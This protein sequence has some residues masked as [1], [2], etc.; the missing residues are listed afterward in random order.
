MQHTHVTAKARPDGKIA[1]EHPHRF[2]QVW[3][4][5]PTSAQRQVAKHSAS[6]K[7]RQHD[8]AALIDAD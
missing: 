3:Q 6:R 2:G 4:A 1:A 5:E 8:R 7:R